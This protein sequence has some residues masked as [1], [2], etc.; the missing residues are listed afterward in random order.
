VPFKSVNY[1]NGNAEDIQA[2][3]E[4]Y[5]KLMP[6][7]NKAVAVKSAVEGPVSEKCPASILRKHSNA[8]LYLD[9]DSAS[10]LE[11]AKN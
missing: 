1:L 3:C 11:V 10:E 2:E 9:E 5:G 6:G 8:V 7:K 4:R